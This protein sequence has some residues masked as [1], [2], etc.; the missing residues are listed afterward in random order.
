[1]AECHLPKVEVA[2]STPV[3]RFM[4]VLAADEVGRGCLAGPLCVGGVLVPVD[5]EKIPGVTDSKKLSP[6]AREVAFN[7]LADVERVVVLI[8]AAA[9]DRD[10]MAASLKRAF[11]QVVKELLAKEREI[12]QVLIDGSP[13]PWLF[14]VPVEYIVK[15]DALDWRIGA[16]S[17][18]AKV[19]RDRLMVEAA[20]KHPGY[21][22][23]S[24]MGYGSKDHMAAIERRGLTPMHRATFCRRFVKH[25][26]VLDLFNEGL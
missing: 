7:R 6:K 12:S 15:G 3:V 9:I 25:D 21:G 2:G 10:G 22:W 1:M 4:Y 20:Q 5:Q 23:E 16:A 17:I 26:N 8:P 18:I 19:T 11:Q 14:P 13:M 24:N